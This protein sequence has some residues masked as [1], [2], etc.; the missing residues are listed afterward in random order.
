M[1][2]SEGARAIAVHFLDGVL[3]ISAGSGGLAQD[4]LPYQQG[5]PDPVFDNTEFK[6][7]MN[8]I[9]LMGFVQSVTGEI[10]FQANADNAPV[11][12][13]AGNR[14]LMSAAVVGGE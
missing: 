14:K 9:H 12:L 4:E 11:V 2:P 13:T 1:V 10:Q 8:F 7:R 6:T 5:D 3:K